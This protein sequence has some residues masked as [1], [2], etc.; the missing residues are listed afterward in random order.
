MGLQLDQRQLLG[1][2]G[3]KQ[4]QRY[5]YLLLLCLVLMGLLMKGLVVG[6]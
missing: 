3:H 1:V 4:M 5:Q 2:R 6:R